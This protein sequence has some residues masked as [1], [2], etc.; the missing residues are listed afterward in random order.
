MAGTS[1]PALDVSQGW[2]SQGY[3]LIM[4]PYFSLVH[5]HSWRWFNKGAGETI[6]RSESRLKILAHYSKIFTDSTVRGREAQIW[7]D[8]VMTGIHLP[9]HMS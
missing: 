2:A 9:A 3:S 5:Q 1:A 8:Q 4:D 6:K 7:A